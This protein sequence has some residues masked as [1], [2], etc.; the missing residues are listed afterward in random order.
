MNRRDTVLGLLALS[1][2][3]L[4]A[5]AQQQGKVWRIGFLSLAS[6]PSSRD[7]NFRQ[8]LL[9]HG[10]VVGRNVTIEYRWADGNRERVPELAAELVRL[11]VDVIVTSSTPLVE[12]A[13][14]ATRTIPIVM[15]A[16]ADAVDAGLVDSLARPGGNVTGLTLMSAELGGKKL[17]LV[18]ELLPKATRVALLVLGDAGGTKALLKEI[19]PLAQ[20]MGIQIFVQALND[21]AQN[22][23]ALFAAMQRERAQSLIVQLNPIALQHRTRIVELAAQYHLP[24][25][26]ESSDFTDAGALV[27]YG[28]NLPDLYRRAGSYVDKIFKGAKPADLPIEQPTK[29]ELVINLKTAR[30]LGTKIPQSLL[31]RADRVIE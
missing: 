29:I 7:E 18:R 14:R 3:P 19:R 4:A 22:L 25:I 21:Q 23:P 2:S 17:Q 24:A 13:K 10:Y 12:A 15:A 26:F 31:V 27:S 20:R 9:E 1:V 16:V 6:G 8:G 30:A 11:N 28:P 5:Q